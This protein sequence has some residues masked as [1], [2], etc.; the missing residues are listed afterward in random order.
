[1]MQEVNVH[2][3]VPYKILS[4]YPSFEHKDKVAVLVAYPDGTQ[5]VLYI[6]QL[7]EIKS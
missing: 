7:S 3:S 4:V 2:S 6:V 5:E 1:M